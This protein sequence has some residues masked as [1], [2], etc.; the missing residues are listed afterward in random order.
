MGC[1]IKERIKNMEDLFIVLKKV[2]DHSL[3]FNN[4][5]TDIHRVHGAIEHEAKCLAMHAQV[6]CECK[7]EE[8][9]K[10][11]DRAVKLRDRMKEEGIHSALMDVAVSSLLTA[12]PRWEDFF[13]LLGLELAA[14]L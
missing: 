3:T 11:A 2:R 9:S 12:G 14:A 8:C 10:H 7:A 13:K 6:G 1:E 4:R 5:D